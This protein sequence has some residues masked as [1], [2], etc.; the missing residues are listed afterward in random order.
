M[1][2]YAVHTPIDAKPADIA[3]FEAKAK[4]LGLD[5]CQAIVP[6][7]KLPTHDWNV[8]RRVIQSDPAYAAMIYNLDWNIGRL[9][10]ALRDVGELDNT[11]VIFTSDRCV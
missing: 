5:K 1:C 11:L 9:I 3:R 6:G 8:M 7:E 10:D 4:Q 2:H